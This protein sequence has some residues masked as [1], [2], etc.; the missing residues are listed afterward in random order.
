MTEADAGARGPGAAAI[1]RALAAR[2]PGQVPSV[3][4]T[5]I[6]WRD[7]GPDPLDRV[8]CYEAGDHWHYVG[9]GLSELE[10]K[11]SADPEQS[12]WGFEPT[13][14]LAR[15][16]ERAP[17]WPS[18]LLQEV[19]RHVHRDRDVLAVGDILRVSG[20]DLRFDAYLV[21]DD[22]ALDGVETPFGAVR[23]VQLVG[24]QPEELEAAEDWQCAAVLALLARLSPLLVSD[25]NRGS[26]LRDPAL[27][28]E[29]RT[30]MTRDGSSRDFA[31][32]TMLDFER[33]DDQLVL[34]LDDGGAGELVRLLRGRIPFGRGFVLRGPTAAAVFRPEGGG[35]KGPT[36]LGRA[37]VVE[38]APEHALALAASL[39]GRPA[40]CRID[41]MEGLTIRIARAAD[42]PP[43]PSGAEM[44]RTRSR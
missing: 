14:R 42:P 43:A 40:V 27:E 6:A 3:F 19:A 8:V 33:D 1:D 41:E 13:F 12:G 35:S 44:R 17:A 32:V 10:E 24:V 9:Y 22:P 4:P 38:L 34:F 39:V 7:G 20:A 29:V 23:F 2:Y 21:A 36:G 31:E 18:V 15:R 11:T 30:G 16:G 25:P 26:L 37:C 28:R 5:L